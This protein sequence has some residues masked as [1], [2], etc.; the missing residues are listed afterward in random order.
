MV[1]GEVRKAFGIQRVS[2]TDAAAHKQPMIS[3][4]CR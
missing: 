1:A 2:P 3:T 4:C